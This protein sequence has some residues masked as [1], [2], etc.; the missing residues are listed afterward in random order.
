MPETLPTFRAADFA[1]DA[2]AGQ[3]VAQARLLAP[4]FAG[5]A[6]AEARSTRSAMR[7]RHFPAPL[8]AASA[9]PRRL[10]RAGTVPRPDGGVQ[11]F[12]R[13]FL[14]ADCLAALPRPDRRGR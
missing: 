1:G 2:T 3:Q 10:L 4:F 7:L 8:Q 9:T 5:D 13:G 11:G 6:L 14:A 12:R